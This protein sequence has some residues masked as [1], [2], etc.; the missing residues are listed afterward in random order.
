[1][2]ATLTAAPAPVLPSRGWP[3]IVVAAA[4]A[5]YSFVPSGLSA[6]LLAIFGRSGLD[7]ATVVA[8]GTL[9]GPSQVIAR[10]GELAFARGVHP[11]TVA[12]FAVA[13]LLVAFAL[14]AWLGV[15]VAIAAAFVVMFGIANGLITLRAEPCRSHCSAPPV[16]AR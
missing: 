15:S 3:F 4:F 2:V 11:L 13:V 10:I 14:L 12:R 8:L 7:A 9:F 5:A 16:T 1:V 6:H